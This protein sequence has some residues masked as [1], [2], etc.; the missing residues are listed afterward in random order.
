MEKNEQPFRP[1]AIF[2]DL[3]ET[4][5]DMTEVERRMNH[6]LD[7]KR[8]YTL[9]FELMMQ[10]CFAD[11]SYATYHPFPQ[12]AKAT[13]QMT[14][15]MLGH[16][17]EESAVNDLFQLLEHLP[18]HDGVPEGLSRLKDDGFVV[19]AL[20]NAPSAIVQNRMEF[21][22]LISYFDKV[23]STETV[24]KYKPA[25]SV[26]EWALKQM[27]VKAEDA[28]LVSTHGWDI[29]GA[30]NVGMKAAY[31]KHPRRML[32]PL[33]PQPAFVCE[34][35]EELAKQLSAVAVKDSDRGF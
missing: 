11:N 35:L 2:I 18:V 4:M 23:L 26:Y 20:T 9:W 28:L 8:G 17:V 6:L 12:I 14:A 19:A 31:L 10:Y 21:S 1:Q 24:K 7:S 13:M 34:S 32:Y 33:A 5:L 29:A 27:D 15:R 22:G 16:H 25:P 3:Y 30:Y